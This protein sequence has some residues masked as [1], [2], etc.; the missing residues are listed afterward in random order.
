MAI[1]HAPS[2]AL[3]GLA[4]FAAVAALGCSQ[5]PG[6]PAPLEVAAGQA[7][8]AGPIARAQSAGSGAA[9]AA[10]CPANAPVLCGSV[11]CPSG[12]TCAAGGGCSEG[13]QA[14]SCPA[15]LPVACT[16]APICA[17]GCAALD[18]SPNDDTLTLTSPASFGSGR[19]GGGAMPATSPRCGAATITG[20]GNGMP[21]GDGAETIE[22]WLRGDL[23]GLATA[24]LFERA[25]RAITLTTAAISWP[26]SS[27]AAPLNAADG[28]WH[29][30]AVTY[31][32]GSATISIDGG[33]AKTCAVAAR[34]TPASW[35]TLGG[36]QCTYPG[37]LD[38]VRV[39]TRA[40]AAGEIAADFAAGPLAVT[41]DTA[42][43]WHFDEGGATRCCPS[44]SACDATGGCSATVLT[45]TSAVCPGNAPVD[46]HDG[47]C[48]PDGFSCAS[49]GVCAPVDAPV[50]PGGTSVDCNDG[51]CCPSG[52]I[53]SGGAC[54]GSVGTVTTTRACADNMY[55]PAGVNALPITAIDA[56]TA[57]CCP[58]TTPSYPQ[59]T[60]STDQTCFSGQQYRCYEPNISYSGY[61]PYDYSAC[62]GHCWDLGQINTCPDNGVLCGANRCCPGGM[63]CARAGSSL[64]CPAGQV[65]CD[66]TSSNCCPASGP[67]TPQPKACAAGTTTCGSEC[68]PSGSACVNNQCQ[69]V[70]AAPAVCANGLA[71]G[72]SCCPTNTRCE[73]PGVCENVPLAPGCPAGFSGAC[74]S[75]G[76][77]CRDGF[78]CMGASGGTGGYYCVAQGVARG[79][80]TGPACGGP[81]Q[82]CSSGDQCA[83]GTCC[84]SDHPALCGAACCLSGAT[85]SAN[86]CGCPPDL[87]V[88]CGADCCASGALCVDGQCV[89]ACSDGRAAC[90]SSCCAPG[91]ECVSGQCAC[92]TD[93]PQSCGNECCL[94]GGGCTN[95]QCTCP[96]GRA[97]CGDQC[98]GAGQSCV[99]GACTDG[100][101]PS[102][103]ADEY[104]AACPGGGTMCCSIHMVCC[105]S[106]GQVGCQFQGFCD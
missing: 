48:C 7:A 35:V 30:V 18:A 47:T 78:V 22:L 39:S 98:C 4:I 82:Y 36:I 51:T 104:A 59:E 33:G 1:E 72:D 84:P 101:A 44:G 27:C 21:T 62:N 55:S 13:A 86:A 103:N 81:D 56:S 88:S 64:C 89:A 19:W 80:P 6:K 49:E 75:V 68:C 76:P 5:P 105:K 90:G 46:C 85:C 96:Q 70:P 3:R 65:A 66:S 60:L 102:C 61:C 26:D 37:T 9:G 14:A 93:H 24:G 17:N 63:D 42:A 2:R 77:C 15:S 43:L 73:S 52:Y 87:P 10:T 8:P 100:G 32:A 23:G 97:G 11:C 25:D 74:T 95:G 28:R 38:E 83:S 40:L 29:F 50:C 31:A 79:G 53:C 20:P 12:D 99:N 54:I 71:C 45:G 92:P 67:A 41:A 57:L 106:G 94:Q 91:I 16:A 58:D 69:A 34:A